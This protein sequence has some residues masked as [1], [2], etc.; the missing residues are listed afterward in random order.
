MNILVINGDCMQ[1]NTSANLCHLAYIRGLLQ[2]VQYTFYGVSFYEKLS[3]RKRANT[4]SAGPNPADSIWKKDE[5]IWKQRLAT[6]RTI[7]SAR[8]L[9]WKSRSLTESWIH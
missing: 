4:T 9:P 8:M 7:R 5:N 3:L 2:V 1:T 6:V